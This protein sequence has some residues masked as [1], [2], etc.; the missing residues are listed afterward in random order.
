MIVAPTRDARQPS[1]ITG[2]DGGI[3]HR[4]F[5]VYAIIDGCRSI[6]VHGHTEVNSGLKI[7]KIRNSNS[8]LKM[9][10]YILSSAWKVNDAVQRS[11]SQTAPDFLPKNLILCHGSSHTLTGTFPESKALV[12]PRPRIDINNML[13]TFRY[14]KVQFV[15]RP[16]VFP[17]NFERTSLPHD[18][19]Y[20]N[21]GLDWDEVLKYRTQ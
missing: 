14:L 13:G 15:E 5:L 17:S 1:S 8:G 9:P 2:W 3:F 7:P 20:Q 6:S 11:S 18:E 10:G 4:Y 19:R 21:L 12:R 16:S